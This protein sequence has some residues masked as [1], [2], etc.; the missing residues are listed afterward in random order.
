M[1]Q[2]LKQRLFELDGADTWDQR[3]SR[4]T[5]AINCSSNAVTGFSPFELET[6]LKGQNLSDQ[7]HHTRADPKDTALIRETALERIMME[8]EK[9]VEKHDQPN[10]EPFKIGDLVLAKNHRQ[11][12][13]RFVGPFKICRV[14]GDGL[15]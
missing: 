7:I 8:K 2:T 12:M 9:R 6:G 14:R 1:N 15:T 11:N 4:I 5:H 13:P 10:F 3:L